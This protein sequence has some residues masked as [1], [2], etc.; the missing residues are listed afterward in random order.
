MYLHGFPTKGF[1]LDLVVKSPS[2]SNSQITN[3]QEL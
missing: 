3:F 1:T 2:Y